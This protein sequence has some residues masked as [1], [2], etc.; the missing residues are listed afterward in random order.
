M[1]IKR[2]L[3]KA[4]KLLAAILIAISLFALT[5]SYHAWKIGLA[6]LGG[7]LYAF[8][9]T[10][11]LYS[12]LYLVALFLLYALAANFKNGKA[13]WYILAG[14]LLGVVLPVMSGVNFFDIRNKGIPFD[15]VGYAVSGAAYGW[16]CYH[17]FFK[18]QVSIT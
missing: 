12:W 14:V 7:F 13:Y 6:P 18:K 8:I 10:L 1:Q 11:T 16:L 3:I 2:Y 4:G 9:L 17:W 5:G 15:F